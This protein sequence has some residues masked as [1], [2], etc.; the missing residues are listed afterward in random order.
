MEHFSVAFSKSRWFCSGSVFHFLL[1]NLMRMEKN[2]RI[3]GQDVFI[4]SKIID[5]GCDLL[6]G[7]QAL[8]DLQLLKVKFGIRYITSN[9]IKSLSCNMSQMPHGGTVSL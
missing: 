3:K 7:I 6:A 5:T 2:R 4:K 9:H 1:S 8:L